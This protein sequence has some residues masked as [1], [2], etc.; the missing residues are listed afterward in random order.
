MYL[1]YFMLIEIKIK[2]T[3]IDDRGWRIK[4]HYYL[5]DCIV[6]IITYIT[7]V[8]YLQHLEEKCKYKK[9]RP[10]VQITIYY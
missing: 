1:F 2:F 8:D 6:Y 5:T 4:T 9:M 7:V 10:L 3:V